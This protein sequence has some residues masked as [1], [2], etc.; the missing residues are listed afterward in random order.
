MS[1][2]GKF[3]ELMT[4]FRRLERE[5]ERYIARALDGYSLSPNEITV[6]SNANG[7]LTASQ[8]AR[9]NGV[10][11][12]LVSRSVK[13]LTAK[14]LIEVVESPTDRRETIITLTKDGKHLKNI[15]D[16]ANEKFALSAMAD[17]S[18]DREEV[19]KALLRLM[20]RSV[21]GGGRDHA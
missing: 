12:A 19:L 10:S 14:G 1:D 6:V 21:D 4:L 18:S 5:Y 11:K 20:I 3:S 2:Y 13:L 15:I 8:I 7:K 16:G 17:I 9:K